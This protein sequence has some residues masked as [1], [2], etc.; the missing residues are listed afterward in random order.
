MNP[1][2][3]AIAHF[4]TDEDAKQAG[5]TEPLTDKEAKLLDGMNRHDR[6]AWLSQKRQAEKRAKP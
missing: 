4:E 1:D 5:F 3:G 6:R 2:T